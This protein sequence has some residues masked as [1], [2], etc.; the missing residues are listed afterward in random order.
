[1]EIT[2]TPTGRAPGG[3][4]IH[5]NPPGDADLDWRRSRHKPYTLTDS[6]PT[7]GAWDFNPTN[8]TSKSA[9]L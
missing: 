8:T 2:G 4:K 1:M 7:E 9:G 5:R 3:F 6:R